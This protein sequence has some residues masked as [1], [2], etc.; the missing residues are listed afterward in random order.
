MQLHVTIRQ[1]SNTKQF[2][3]KVLNMSA[4]DFLEFLAQLLVFPQSSGIV[5]GRALQ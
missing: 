2:I 1:I 4:L 5:P 3:A